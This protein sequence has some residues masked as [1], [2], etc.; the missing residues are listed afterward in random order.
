MN[1]FLEGN[2]VAGFIALFHEVGHKLGYLHT[3]L[4]GLGKKAR[5]GLRSLTTEEMKLPPIQDGKRLGLQDI[6]FG[7]ENN[8]LLTIAIPRKL[9]GRKE[10]GAVQVPLT[11]KDEIEQ[12]AVP[13]F[14]KLCEGK[15]I[16]KILEGLPEGELREI[17][18]EAYR[19]AGNR[20]D[21]QRIGFYVK[22]KI[23]HN[24]V[25][26]E[27]QIL[28]WL[29]EFIQKAVEK[30]EDS[31]GSE[32]QQIIQSG[33]SKCVGFSK[34]LAAFSYYF[35]IA[36]P[37]ISV[38]TGIVDVTIDK[39]SKKVGHVAN[40]IIRKGRVDVEL[41]D[42]GYGE[43][44][45]V[46][47]RIGLVVNEKI[48]YMDIQELK[49]DLQTGRI[50]IRQI[51]GL[52]NNQIDAITLSNRGAE[53]TEKATQAE[54]D[55]DYGAAERLREESRR[56]SKMAY[57]YNK[58]IPTVL[59]NY[60]S[61]LINTDK[62]TAEKVLQDALRIDPESIETLLVYIRW[63][64]AQR[65]FQKGNQMIAR[66]KEI[67]KVR[68]LKYDEDFLELLCVFAELL[69]EKGDYNGAY[70]A[71]QDAGK[72]KNEIIGRL[73]KEIVKYRTG[74]VTVGESVDEGTIDRMK[75]EFEAERA[76]RE[77]EVD[78]LQKKI[79]RNKREIDRMDE[80]LKQMDNSIEEARG[81]IDRYSQSSVDNFNAMVREFQAK[82]GQR[83]DMVPGHNKMAERLRSLIDRFNADFGK[84][85]VKV[86]RL[87]AMIS[88]Y[89]Q[90]QRNET[91]DWRIKKAE[92]E[93]RKIEEKAY[94]LLLISAKVELLMRNPDKPADYLLGLK[95]VREDMKVYSAK[96]IA[97]ICFDIGNMYFSNK[98][99]KQA[100]KYYQ[101]GI[102]I[103]RRYSISESDAL[104]KLFKS[105]LQSALANTGDVGNLV[106]DSGADARTQAIACLNAGNVSFQGE[107]WRQAIENYRRGID[108]CEKK[109]LTDSE[110]YGALKG[111]LGN[112]VDNF[113]ITLLNEGKHE[114]IIR[115][116]NAPNSLKV[117]AYLSRGNNFAERTDQVFSE[118]ILAF[119]RGDWQMASIK[120]DEVVRLYNEAIRNYE[121]GIELDPSNTALQENR[122][123]AVSNRETALGNRDAAR[124][125]AKISG[126]RA[127]DHQLSNRDA[128]DI[129]QKAKGHE[130]VVGL[131][132]IKDKLS[133]EEWENFKRVCELA[134]FPLTDKNV[135]LIIVDTDEDFKAH[136]GNVR[137]TGGEAIRVFVKKSLMR[138]KGIGF[139]LAHE[140]LEGQKLRG[141][142]QGKRNPGESLVDA[143]AR[144][145]KN[146]EMNRLEDEAHHWAERAVLKGKLRD[147]ISGIGDVRD[148]KQVFFNMLDILEQI[149]E[150][151]WVDRGYTTYKD[152]KWHD[153]THAGTSTLE[154]IKALLEMKKQ[155]VPISDE[156][157]MLT[158]IAGMMHDIGYYIPNMELGVG[159]ETIKVDHEQRSME[160]VMQNYKMLGLT[161]RDL[162]LV[163][164]IIAGT[165]VSVTAGDWN[166]L[167]EKIEIAK[168]EGILKK[169][170]GENFNKSDI[171][172]VIG[173]IDVTDIELMNGVIDGAKI[174]AT[175]DIYD[176][177]EDAL[178]KIYNLREE[179]KRDYDVIM[180][181]LGMLYDR[182][183]DRDKIDILVSRVK[184]LKPQEKSA[185]KVIEILNELGLGRGDTNKI[186]A[187]SLIELTKIALSPSGADQIAGTKFFNIFYADPRVKDLGVLQYVSNSARQNIDIAR[188]VVFYLSEDKGTLDDLRAKGEE[189]QRSLLDLQRLAA[190]S[191]LLKIGVKDKTE[192]TELKKIIGENPADLAE[193]LIKLLKQDGDVTE[194]EIKI[195]IEQANKV[196]E[197]FKLSNIPDT[198]E[199]A[200][201]KEKIA[202][203]LAIEVFEKAEEPLF[204]GELIKELSARAD[205]A[206]VSEDMVRGLVE[207]LYKYDQYDEYF[208]LM[209][210]GI[211][212]LFDVK[213]GDNVDK[214]LKTLERYVF[215]KSKFEVTDERFVGDSA[216][217][218]NVVMAYRNKNRQ[219]EDKQGAKEILSEMAGII[220]SYIGNEEAF[221]KNFQDDKIKSTVRQGLDSLISRKQLRKQ[222]EGELEQ[223]LPKEI[224]GN[225]IERAKTGYKSFW[226]KIDRAGILP[227]Q[228]Q[229]NMPLIVDVNL[230]GEAILPVIQERAEKG[231]LAILYK[232]KEEKAAIEK[233]L[234]DN[235]VN[236]GDIDFF[237]KYPTEGKYAK[238]VSMLTKETAD[239]I[240]DVPVG[241]RVV[242]G[243]EKGEDDIILMS[244]IA[245]TLGSHEN[246]TET[247]GP[248]ESLFLSYYNLKERSELNEEAK[249]ILSALERGEGIS[250]LVLS[251]PPISPF[252]KAYYNTL[253]TA[254]EFIAIAA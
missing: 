146:G 232:T 235:R 45:L 122:R 23:S 29:F 78:E 113:Y 40:V 228:W 91:M 112:A 71:V 30:D 242:K 42:L 109:G 9:S 17:F 170:L 171:A 16:E 86:Q 93:K 119:E 125:N 94:K 227:A 185:E 99:W 248:M 168:I 51:R 74:K 105:N 177:R 231:Q 68:G 218:Y 62:T 133:P 233:W 72:I 128:N 108:V 190:L 244:R 144:L 126:G 152:V 225:G 209:V 137:M 12:V 33:K 207:D 166:N 149:E 60:A 183:E 145:E 64:M 191:L 114:E 195:V 175:L 192:I 14:E 241:H 169:V 203:F 25:S 58:D 26:F 150:G 140:F 69:L 102:E 240:K 239:G 34:M 193:A 154:G 101:N 181:Y 226:D 65:D 188:A 134:G 75:V 21:I 130:D 230:I 129:I 206:G 189:Y 116:N 106:G 139:T 77:A 8:N 234:G 115:D 167:G 118:G 117:K 247:A 56:Y 96:K 215:I 199:N 238:A 220:S 15:S 135:K 2:D 197:I 84:N 110:V 219:G 160:F 221:L 47:V 24:R 44:G 151:Q 88:A 180:R 132:N 250:A 39:E 182:D 49:N 229:D 92:K 245:G 158:G 107:D 67:Y 90:G 222:L 28:D 157:I 249:A 61:S 50:N 1:L 223:K 95:L 201:M 213:D 143:S 162:V 187:K 79:D 253:K 243:T 3:K 164:L 205:K 98:D 59:T 224:L 236:L 76:R 13:L 131:D 35:G 194:D 176:S 70:A 165:Q 210:D 174:L 172:S 163:C 179:F 186:I 18:I 123:I 153:F 85:G 142:I 43:K 120:F 19:A 198:P 200:Q 32:L 4:R 6:L 54:M 156:A 217:M 38:Y 155:G 147:S 252:I 184:A 211:R 124:S 173:S 212:T 10:A 148:L 53:L 141:F 111:N 254:R 202:I 208:A 237:D 216:G 63:C 89:N 37:S 41:Y 196:E 251:L 214:Y 7:E 31:P 159:Y 52:S 81:R 55:G 204:V 246:L 138:D 87:Q 36:D 121:M 82:Q 127:V 80:E 178:Q 103:L 48:R 83:N 97:E 22:E 161:E 11:F 73:D 5:Q 20:W 66:V 136:Y 100:A 57:E 104:Y 46:H 27:L